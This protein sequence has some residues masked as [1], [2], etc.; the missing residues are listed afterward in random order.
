MS[1]RRAGGSA[2]GRP[3]PLP[4][5]PVPRC[6][7]PVRSS[8]PLPP[9]PGTCGRSLLLYPSAAR[10]TELH[11]HPSVHR[12]VC[13]SIVPSAHLPHLHPAPALR[14][15]VR[16]SVRPSVPLQPHR[17]THPGGS[18]PSRGLRAVPGVRIYPGGSE[19]ARGS[20]R[21]G[22][23]GGGKS[24]KKSPPRRCHRNPQPE[25]V[26]PRPRRLPVPPWRSPPRIPSRPARGPAAAP[27]LPTG[28]RRFR[29]PLLPPH[30]PSPCPRC[31]PQPHTALPGPEA[32]APAP[33]GPAAIFN[34]CAISVPRGR[35]PPHRSL[36]SP[37]RRGPRSPRG[38]G[39]GRG[40]R[41]R[42]AP[43][44]PGRR[45]GRKD[46]AV[47]SARPDRLQRALPV[48]GARRSPRVTAPG[49]PRGGRRRNAEGRGALWCR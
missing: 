33:H 27:P 34:R 44:V 42:Q 6:S 35:A 3:P 26:L 10:C 43:S 13:P 14:S 18:D 49:Q 20:R 32:A 48:P 39:S 16:L 47:I 2:P 40:P 9:V 7:L 8:P 30:P 25:T 19:P 4:V 23:F 37:R 31:F 22:G 17:R 46:R 21:G 41:S 29:S 45:R 38:T 5:P 12:S 28:G 24:A 36:P 1:A 15:P 11:L